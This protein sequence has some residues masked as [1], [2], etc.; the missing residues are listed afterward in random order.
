VDIPP[1][2]LDQTFDDSNCMTPL[3]FVLSSGADPRSELEVVA[4]KKGMQNNLITMSL[5]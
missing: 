5:G 4:L 2:D 3:I 1:F